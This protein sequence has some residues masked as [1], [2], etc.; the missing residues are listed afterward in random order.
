MEFQS[1]SET[2]EHFSP[3]I[4][5][6][7][8]AVLFISALGDIPGKW[9]LGAVITL[10]FVFWCWL[11]LRRRLRQLRRL[12]AVLYPL[13]IFFAWAVVWSIWE[14]P[15]ISGLENLAVLLVFLGLILYC[16][17]S[18]SPEST[19]TLS[20]ALVLAVWV[21]SLLYGI[22]LFM[23]GPGSSS[24]IG[25]RIFGLSALLGISWYVARW[26]YGVPRSLEHA[27]VLLLLVAL[28]L[29]RTAFAIG[30]FLFPLASVTAAKQNGRLRL[31]AV[32]VALVVITLTAMSQF[33]PFTERIEGEA[34][35]T[36]AVN[37][38]SVALDTSGR[39]LMW[40]LVW[41]SY[42]D[43]PWAGKGV[44][45]AADL[46]D[47]TIPGVSHPHCDYLM[48]LHDYG[49]VGL[50]LFVFGFGR[51]T[52]CLWVRRKT[53]WNI[54][55]STMTIPSATLFLLVAIMAAMVTDNCLSYT[56]LMAPLAIMIGVSFRSQD[57]NLAQI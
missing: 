55:Q 4:D 57:S 42:L 19:I 49:I 13:L 3:K 47:S 40:A 8:V 35:P 52:R 26:C 30:I 7:A 11:P 39:L 2:A 16:S 15:L 23:G 21:A 1:V 18:E 22:S 28:S 32:T 33:T 24:I 29:S 51:L 48:V 14:R 37:V 25:A 54:H 45:S 36:S 43:S 9:N 10:F 17:E 5:S 38:G 44:G 12:L 20:T 56:F 6:F 53:A 31:T 34:G 46:V 41:E 50:L 27:A